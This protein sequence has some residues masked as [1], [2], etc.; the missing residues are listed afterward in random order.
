MRTE[1]LIGK[2]INGSIDYSLTPAPH[3]YGTTLSADVAQTLTLPTAYKSYKVVFSFA[4]GS[5][6]F[7]AYNQTAAAFGGSFASSTSEY[8]PQVREINGGTVLSFLT[9]DTSA[10]VGVTYYGNTPNGNS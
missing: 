2:D 10:F 3:K 8:L 1:W 6:V 9:P 5:N 4:G 7:V